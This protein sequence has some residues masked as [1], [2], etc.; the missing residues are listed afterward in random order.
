MSTSSP[1]AL[2]VGSAAK[3]APKTPA[4]AAA[5]VNADA[6]EAT[7]AESGISL[8][9]IAAIVFGWRV[10]NHGSGAGSGVPVEL[11]IRRM[12]SPASMWPTVATV[13]AAPRVGVKLEN[14][15]QPS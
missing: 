10:A 6:L 7:A 8:A 14:L 3:A 11:P 13:E 4:P 15:P 2:P 1:L 9:A 12:A 5:L